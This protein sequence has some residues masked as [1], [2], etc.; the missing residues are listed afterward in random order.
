LKAEFFGLDLIQHPCD[1][2]LGC[3]PQFRRRG[4]GVGNDYPKEQ[5]DVFLHIFGESIHDPDDI[6]SQG[7]FS[8]LYTGSNLALI[9]QSARN[10]SHNDIISRFIDL[11]ASAYG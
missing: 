3:L 11:R 4:C 10:Y 2:A 5:R 8:P 1:D 7:A 6:G 9:D